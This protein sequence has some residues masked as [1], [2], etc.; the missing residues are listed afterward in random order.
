M[1]KKI[2]AGLLMVVMVLGFVNLSPLSTTV[3]AFKNFDVEVIKDSAPIREGYYETKKAIDWV[4]KGT[5]L[6]IVDDKLNL[7]LRTWYKVKGGGWIYSGNVK[8][9]HD[10]KVVFD[11]YGKTHPHLAEYR[12]KGCDIGGYCGQETTKVKGCAECYPPKSSSS[13]TESKKQNTNKV[14]NSN[15]TT[16]SDILAPSRDS[17]QEEVEKNLGT[18]VHK[19][20]YEFSKYSNSHPHYAIYSCSC[21]DGYEDKTKTRKM[22]GCEICYPHTHK[23]ELKGYDKVHP[24][25]ANY[26]CS[27]GNG[28][29]KNNETTKVKTCS[30]CYPYGYGNDHFCQFVFSGKYL[31]EHPHHAINECKVCGKQEIDYDRTKDNSSCKI[32]NDPFRENLEMYPDFH[33]RVYDLT[34]G[35]IIYTPQKVTLDEL[36]SFAES[37]HITLDT[38]GLIP[39]FGEI[40]DGINALYYIVEGDYVNAALSGMAVVPIIGTVSTTGKIT[41]NVGKAYVK[42]SAQKAAGRIAFKETTEEVAEKV[43]IKVTSKNVKRLS[44]KAC[45]IINNYR[46]YPE[47]V[48]RTIKNISDNTSIK[49]NKAFY[50]GDLL[51]GRK[52]TEYVEST[53]TGLKY[54]YDS[55]LKKHRFYHILD[56][57]SA[58]PIEAG[59][60]LFKT[61]GKEV[62][63][64][65]ERTY[66]KHKVLDV[67]PQGIRTAY[68]MDAGEVIGKNNERYMLIVIENGTDVISAYP[69]ANSKF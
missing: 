30:Q 57:H 33:G 37:M 17:F 54:G 59:G 55:K 13:S 29:C 3:H 9:A 47:S 32:C 6:T 12:C 28:Y 26:A 25:V 15:V 44:E 40:F 24:H 64:T 20:N 61:T 50:N 42:E 52:Y 36:Y 11:K 56:K 48:L 62:I 43:A 34:T 66:K 18:P 27:C 1:L 46:E 8:K 53:Y 51:V 41:A 35:D 7:K 60:T 39:A 65:I 2:M 49:I 21:K 63:D 31:N 45:R 38:L 5:R 19:H 22:T 16:N 23:Y 10:H 67:N 4:K 14:P 69:Y 68:I 58:N